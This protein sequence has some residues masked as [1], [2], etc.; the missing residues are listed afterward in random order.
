MVNTPNSPSVV[1]SRTRRVWVFAI[2]FVVLAPAG[3]FLG[4]S[5]AGIVAIVA[6][7]GPARVVEGAYV[8]Y[9]YKGYVINP[10][11]SITYERPGRIDRTDAAGTISIPP[12]LYLKKPFHTWRKPV[13]R[14][15]YAPELHYARGFHR[16]LEGSL[17]GTVR[18]TFKVENFAEDPAQWE[19]SIEDLYA[20][21]RDLL[22]SRK[23][24]AP[25]ITSDAV[26]QAFIDAVF[27]EYRALVAAHADTKR[28][29]AILSDPYFKTLSSEDQEKILARQ[30]ADIARF[31]TWGPYLEYKWT[32]RLDDLRKGPSAQSDESRAK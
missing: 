14:A 19:Q 32:R 25:F 17:L 6:S 3:C 1:H 23:K 13:V 9:S 28:Q 12:S 27:H 29:I 18:R 10:V 8:A 22:Y 26:I 24:S 21:A 30:R 20:L 2:V 31:P 11:D 15:I 4:W 5:P 16:P 7:D